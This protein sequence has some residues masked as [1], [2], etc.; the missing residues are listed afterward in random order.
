MLVVGSRD[1]GD[2]RITTV[3]AYLSVRQ[4]LRGRSQQ[5]QTRKKGPRIKRIFKNITKHIFCVLCSI[6]TVMEEHVGE[7]EAMLD[8]EL[9]HALDGSIADRMEDNHREKAR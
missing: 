6:R 8:E 7:L 5:R 1:R 9:I 3:S 4:D 2:V